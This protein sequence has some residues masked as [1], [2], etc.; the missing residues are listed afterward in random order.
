MSACIRL[1]PTR[2]VLTPATGSIEDNLS[3]CQQFGNIVVKFLI[4]GLT[5]PTLD[6]ADRPFELMEFHERN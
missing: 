1:P 3:D 6:V 2:L 5:H 4:A